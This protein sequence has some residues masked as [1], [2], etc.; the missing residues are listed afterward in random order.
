M[1]LSAQMLHYQ[2]MLK[3]PGQC[4][5]HNGQLVSHRN[6]ILSKVLS[7]KMIKSGKETLW[8]LFSR[9]LAVAISYL[10]CLN[11]TFSPSCL[12]QIQSVPIWRAPSIHN[13]KE[14]V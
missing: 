11:A 10:R 8:I 3:V 13:I 14:V 1:L 4:T 12:T 9:P 7:M 5:I 6:I 2:K